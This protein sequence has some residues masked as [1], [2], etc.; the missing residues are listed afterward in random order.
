LNAVNL[1]AN[2][3]A[4]AEVFAGKTAVRLDDCSFSYRAIDAASARVAGLL[5]QRGVRPAD[6]VALMLPNVPQF[7][8]VYYGILRVGA[9]AVLISALL[10]QHDVASL[11]ADSGAGLLFAWH[12]LA[13]EAE[14]GA[15]GP[16]SDCLFVTPREF[17]RLLSAAEPLREVR[18]RG[19][20]EPAVIAYT[21][22]RAGRRRADLNHAALARRARTAVQSYALGDDDIVLGTL[23]LD[24]A[25]AHACS[26][27]A[28][29][30]SG[31]TLSLMNR[32]DAGR[33]LDVVERDRV[34]VLHGAPSIYRAMLEHPRRESFDVSTLRLCVSVG[35]PLYPEIEAAFGC[36]AIAVDDSGSEL[37]AGEPARS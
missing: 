37:A 29:L 6:R 31:A 13:E 22:S 8:V 16:G 34:T 1:A 17:D 32:F 5:R 28:A 36:A 30:Q 10:E 11:L 19:S 12:G 23:P 25:F 7:A 21:G 3:T 33:A 14:A 4:S 18:Q 26:L 2:L 15:R 20:G 35:A 24:H 27:N 9:V